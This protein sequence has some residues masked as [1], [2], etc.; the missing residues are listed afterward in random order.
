MK[1]KELYEKG[2]DRKVNPAVSASDLSDDTVLTEIVEYVFTPEIIVNLYKILLNIKQNQGSHVGIWINGYYGSGKSHFLK[3]ASYCLSGNKEHREMAF[4]R[5]KEATH[6]FLMDNKDLTVLEQAGVSESELASLEKWYINSANVEMVLFN[7]GD[8]HDANADSE[9]TFTKIFWNQFNAKRGYNSFNLALAQHLEKALD[10]DG[11]FEEFKEY[12]KSKGYDWERN[13][14]RFAAGSLDLA[15]QFAKDVDPGLA[16][17]V[18]RTRIVNNEINV[19]VEAFAQ[20]MKTY[21]DSKN[22]RHYRIIFFVDEISQFIGTHRDLILQLQSLVKRLD[23]VCESRVW[24]G[25]TA[26]QTL[27]EVVT[28]VGGNTSNPEDE[29]GKILGRFEVR[30]SLQ[31]TS[32]EY[33]TQ[34]RIL[35]K[36]GDMEIMLADLYKKEKAKLDAQFILPSTYSSFKDDKD[37]IACYPFVPYQFQLIMKV[38][39]SFLSLGYVDRQVR[40]NE[41]S[42]LNIAFSIAKETA[43]CE[44]G[45]FVS[46]DRFFNAMLQGSMQHL[47]QRAIENARRA[48]ELIQDE[49]KQ[50]FYRRVVY[51]LFMICHLSEADKQSF[52]ATIDNIVTLLMSKMDAS[53]AAIKNDVSKV[54]DD[55]IDKSVIRKIRTDSG[56]EIYDFY[57]EEES[58][59]A[60]IIKN[61]SVDSNTYIEE[62]YK[63][64]SNHFGFGASS[65]KET[66]ATRSFNVG[67]NVDGRSYMSNNADIVVDFLTN[68]HIDS[69]EQYAFANNPNHIVFF[70]NN[71]FKD[72]LELRRNFSDYCKVQR[73]AKEPAISEERQ[74]T[75]RLFIDRAKDLYTKE[76]VPRFQ[77]ILD[78]CPVI[79]GDSVLSESELRSAKKQERYKEVFKRHME[80]LYEFAKLVEGTEFPKNQSDL[81]TAILRS[82]DDSTLLLPSLSTPEKK[83]KEYLDR[84]LHE[85][86]VGDVISNFAKAPYGW[87]DFATIY[88]VNE[89]VRRHEYAFNYNNNPNVSREDTARYIVKES[90]KFTIEKAQAIPQALINDFIEAWRA[91]FNVM[92]VKGGNDSTELLRN[93]KETDDSELK[94]LHKH[95]DTL[96]R[97]LSQYP[98]VNTIDEALELMDSWLAERDPKKFF[99]IIIDAKEKACNL[100]DRCKSINTFNNDQIDNYKKVLNFLNENRDNFAFLTP[101]QQN[102]V[103]TL[104]TIKSELS[105]WENMPSYM[106]LMR[107][108]NGQLGECK[109]KL[110]ATIR[111]NY[112]KVFDELEKYAEQM[113]VSKDKFARRESTISLKI[114]TSNF[115]ALQA[116]ADTTAFYQAELNKINRAIPEPEP[117]QPTNLHDGEDTPYNKKDG[118]PPSPAPR[119]RKVVSLNTHTT[120]PIRTEADVDLYLQALKAEIMSHLG[121]D[122]DI[123]IN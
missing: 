12:V 74:R 61:Q 25:C 108:L 47:G 123:I 86:T 116:N 103:S 2:L 67:M 72:D 59:V 54:L 89:L 120:E 9:T 119:K 56:A 37:F 97:K 68:A 112:N 73:F 18:I 1:F 52:S 8:V 33:I 58:E 118:T 90:K 16:I 43:E 46:F 94:K 41:R 4:I 106:K 35:E 104:N 40:G 14:T 27:E 76:I 64:I 93:C 20:E 83:V 95:Y 121:G 80:K 3:Y 99:E 45:E 117:E 32:P 101:E 75:K 24:I 122:S 113:N 7:I 51:V 77:H 84:T 98:F 31:G 38:L 69:P 39:D 53:K 82:I 30:A 110:V 65:N 114:N 85:V 42:L 55:L 36:K 23:E 92:S 91:I 63:I 50:V 26:Q 102:S 62:I 78:N 70:L 115:Y 111:D 88:V 81:Q 60:Q 79:I 22:D 6:S 11:K 109:E 21:L 105:P 49:E 87:S 48:V 19:S 44:V 15:L 13:I 57:T 34:K 29:V 107:N 5:L 96:S 66:Y 10:E 100:F 28:T 17:D 71:L